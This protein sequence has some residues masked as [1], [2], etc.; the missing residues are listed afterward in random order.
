MEPISPETAL[1]DQLPTEEAFG[2]NKITAW[3]YIQS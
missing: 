1:L 3:P 2:I